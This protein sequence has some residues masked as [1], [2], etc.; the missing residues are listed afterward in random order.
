MTDDQLYA[1]ADPDTVEDLT[2]A[3]CQAIEDESIPNQT[4]AADILSAL[5]TTTSRFMRSMRKGQN[6]LEQSHNSKEVSR[7]LTSMLM[8]FGSVIH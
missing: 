1:V 5:F 4:S 6:I 8:E 2:L 7:V 3:I